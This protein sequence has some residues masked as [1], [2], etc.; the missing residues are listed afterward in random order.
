MTIA[1]V[2]LAACLVATI[3]VAVFDRPA[4]P[5]PI[6]IPVPPARRTP[7]RPGVQSSAE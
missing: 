1:L 6:R 7:G 5:E 3:L 2:S 4:Q